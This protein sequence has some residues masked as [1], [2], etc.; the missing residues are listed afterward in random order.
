VRAQLTTASL[1]PS[2]GSI[3]IAQQQLQDVLAKHREQVSCLSYRMNCPVILSL[4]SE[5]MDVTAYLVSKRLKLFMLL[6]NCNFLP[7]GC[8]F[9]VLSM[10]LEVMTVKYHSFHATVR[11]K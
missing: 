7:C 3:S 5:C 8:E 10:H 6:F 2:G 4:T 11:F 9:V 1:M